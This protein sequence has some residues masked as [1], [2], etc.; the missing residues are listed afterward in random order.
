VETLCKSTSG[1]DI[2]EADLRMRGPGELLGVR[3]AGLSDLRAADLIRDA[4][5]L[6]TAR[7]EAERLT[8]PDCADTGDL[9]C[10]LFRP[11]NGHVPP[12]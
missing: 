4:R 10:S 12:A 11:E 9:A 7:R 2:A 6:D 5:L 1:F 8:A 3:Q